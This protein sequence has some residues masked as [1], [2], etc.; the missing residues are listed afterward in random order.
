VAAARSLGS[1]AVDVDAARA[2]AGPLTAALA[3]EMRERVRLELADALLA[4]TGIDFGPDAERWKRW[5]VEVNGTFLPPERPRRKVAQRSGT[6]QGHLLELP[7]ESDHVAFVIDFSHSMSDPLRF[8]GKETKRDALLVAFEHVVGRLPDDAWMNVIPFGTEPLPYRPKLFRATRSA[9]AGAI[10]FLHKRAPDGRTNL[11]DSLELA[12]TDPS[13]DTLV[14]V[15][16]GAPSE[17]RHST[18]SSIL[19]GVARLN[20]YRLA[21]IHT[22]EVGARNTSPRWRGFMQQL[23]EA[24]GGSYLAR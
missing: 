16:D 23:A 1:Y 4:L 5:L 10:K 21:R 8:G 6:T 2:A 13:A 19:D 22:V 15:T 12:L 9:R 7:L 14:V 11:Y 17:G 18:R 20:R 3:A 24:A